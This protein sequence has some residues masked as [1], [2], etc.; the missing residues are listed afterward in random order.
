VEYAVTHF[1]SPHPE[2]GASHHTTSDHLI[3]IDGDSAHLNAQF[4]V[5]EVRAAVR[6]EEG[7]PAGTFGRQGTVQPIESGYYDTALRRIDGEWKITRHS[8]LMD[9]PIVLPGA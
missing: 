4:I 1:M 7:W 6:P 8:V 3:E 5:F 9:M 2:G